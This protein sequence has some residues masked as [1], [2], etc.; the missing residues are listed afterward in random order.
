MKTP[1]DLLTGIKT[2]GDFRELTKSARHESAPE[3]D[4]APDHPIWEAWTRLVEYYG[5]AFTYG[6]EPSATW[7]YYLQDMTPEQIGHGIRNLPRHDSAFPPNPGEFR[8]LCVSDFDWEH[9][10]L[11]YVEPPIALEDE[12]AKAK[13]VA[14]GLSAIRN[15]RKDAGL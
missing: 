13:R 4:L 8:D 7:V 14:D 9:R 1:Q 6:P 3:I 10:R 5:A 15:L 12:T 11:K 2:R